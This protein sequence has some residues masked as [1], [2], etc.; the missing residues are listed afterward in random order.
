MFTY[1]LEVNGK[2]ERMPDNVLKTISQFFQEYRKI[3]H[4]DSSSS[5][6]GES[7]STDNQ[8]VSANNDK[9]IMSLI[10]GL[11]SNRQ[12]NYNNGGQ[13][14][15][16]GMSP[17]Y[18][19]QYPNNN[20]YGN[21]GGGSSSML[22]KVGGAAAGF[23]MG[24]MFGG[25]G[26]FGGIT[27]GVSGMA[28]GMMNKVGGLFGRSGSSSNEDPGLCENKEEP[29]EGIKTFKL[30]TFRCPLPNTSLTNKYCCGP[31][32]SQYCCSTPPTTSKPSS[33]GFSP[34]TKKI[35]IGVGAVIVVGII[36]A[37]GY[38]FYKKKKAAAANQI[39][40]NPNPIPNNSFGF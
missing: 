23:F 11:G 33:A 36:G 1:Q 29:G 8:L 20:N 17:G 18:G 13:R 14:Y 10:S 37:V 40:H 12:Q 27:S 39:P 3:K 21:S 28:G 4:L 34:T 30:G 32:G 5:G 25:G 2:C 16:G 7:D 22:K 6:C 15:P 26:G 35:I 31:P 38:Y 9:G 19:Q 24:K